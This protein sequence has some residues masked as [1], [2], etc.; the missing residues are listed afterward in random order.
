MIAVVNKRN[1]KRGDVIKYIL[2]FGK[3]VIIASDV[4]PFPKSILKIASALGS[5]VFYPESPLTNVEKNKIIHDHLEI[6]KDNHQKDALA[7]GLKAFKSYHG[8]FLKIEDALKGNDDKNIF[9]EV[10]KELLK[11]PGENI[12]D[13]IKKVQRKTK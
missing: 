3:P 13:T 10:V 4:N 1:A 8:L 2:A 6:I 7:A 11:Y 12:S 5:R 9:E